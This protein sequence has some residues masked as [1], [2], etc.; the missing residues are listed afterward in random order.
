MLFRSDQIANDSALMF[1][2]R[3]AG[4]VPN[5]KAGRADLWNDLCKLIQLLETIRAVENFDTKTATVTQGET[6]KA[7]LFTLD[8][9]NVT[10]AMAQLYMA[11]YIQ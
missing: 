7:V 1:N 9:L 10:N 11:V 4:L 5:D 3:Y 6:K 2:T 8:S